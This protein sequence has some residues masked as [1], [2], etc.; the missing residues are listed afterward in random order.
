MS[1]ALSLVRRLDAAQ[2]K[3]GSVRFIAIDGHGG[4]GKSTLA[5][6]LAETLGAGIVQ[7]D[8]FASWDN[9]FD[10]WPLVIER[11]FEPVRNGATALNYPRSKWWEDH[12]PEAVVGQPV[13]EIM[14]LEGVSSLRRE[15][16]EF[17][18]FGIFVDTPKELCLQRGVARDG[19]T[20][21]STEEL[22]KI[23]SRWLEDEDAYMRHDDPRGHA[24]L[25]L[26][27][28]RAFEEQF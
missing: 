19:C 10:W 12:C 21:K 6:W 4:S 11:V 25:I 13:T 5:R 17:I 15:F 14:I 20:G 9:P 3:V 23:W 28:I 27:G 16:L 8:D 1:A 2:P 22:T 24:D 26:D 7:T 18:S